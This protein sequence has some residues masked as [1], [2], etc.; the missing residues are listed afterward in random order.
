MKTL[1]TF[2]I[3]FLLIIDS[4]FAQLTTEITI[5]DYKK[6]KIQLKLNNDS[7]SIIKDT[8]ILKTVPNNYTY[9]LTNKSG[10]DFFLLFN[11]TASPSSETVSPYKID[12]AANSDITK[13]SP[14]F[15]TEN[16]PVNISIRNKAD[17]TKSL[18][19]L[20]ITTTTKKEDKKTRNDEEETSEV[21]TGIA[22]YDALSLKNKKLSQT[23]KA[24]IL[25]YYNHKSNLTDT[26]NIIKAYSKNPFIDNYVKDIQ[27]KETQSAGELPGFPS[28]PALGSLDVTILADGFAKFLVKRTKEELAAAFFDRFKEEISD[29]NYQDLQILFPQT[30][31]TLDAIGDQI[32]NYSAY[33]N[34]LR[35]SFEKDLAGLLVNLPSAIDNGNYSNF[36]NKHARLKALCLSS[37]YVGNSLL[38]KEHPGKIIADYDTTLL[39]NVN[40]KYPEIKGAVQTLQLFSES[41]RSL[42]TNHYWVSTDSLKLLLNDSDA[43]NIYFG[44]IYQK[45]SNIVYG[46]GKTLQMILKKA[47]NTQNMDSIINYIN[48]F[49]KQATVVSGNIRNMESKDTTKLNFIDYYNFYNSSLDLIEYASNV[50]KLPDLNTVIPKKEFQKYLTMLRTGGNIALDINRRN[51]S[52]AII[53]TFQLYHFAF[54]STEGTIKETSNKIGNFILKYGSFMAAVVQAQNSDDVEQAIEA[55]ALPQSSYRIK[56][57]SYFDVSLNAYLGLFYGVERIKG[58]D[59]PY[60]F[61]HANYNSFGVTAPIGI[62]FS[63]SI[64][65]TS[66]SLFASIIDIGAPAAFRFSNDSTKQVPTIQLKDII[67]PGIFLSIGIPNWPVSLVYGVQIT[68]S[69]H[70]VTSSMNNYNQ[71][72]TY[73]YSFSLCV[74]I[75]LIDFYTKL[76]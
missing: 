25:N 47:H 61:F 71:A 21:A 14:P 17:L 35:E 16:Y 52:S 13:T 11:F 48:G 39:N 63:T 33:I 37:I 53:N 64:G 32:Y 22:Y 34:A 24:V 70:T 5:S 36:F 31:E 75:P 59:Q 18:K 29:S 72:V 56:R 7:V 42:N 2:I 4:S 10:E 6:I 50:Y 57:E 68:P 51:Y 46:E 65:G 15:N 3:I 23:Q 62:S 20:T 74:D 9:K 44:L 45:C 58:F 60:V 49:L 54:D 27:E 1:I 19:D 69:L 55:V 12:I 28:L 40:K 38:L 41:L 30:Y 76:K 67:S 8:A 73:R 43:R 66:L 26:K